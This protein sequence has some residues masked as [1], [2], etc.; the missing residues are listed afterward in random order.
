MVRSFFFFCIIGSIKMNVIPASGFSD[1]H[2]FPAHVIKVSPQAVD[3]LS[4]K[5]MFFSQVVDVS[6]MVLTVL[7]PAVDVSNQVVDVCSTYE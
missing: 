7:F 2:S 6:S 3:D 1:R 5:W 4:H